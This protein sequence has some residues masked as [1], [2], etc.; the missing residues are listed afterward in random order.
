VIE[1]VNLKM[2]NKASHGT[3]IQPTMQVASS[4]NDSD[5]YSGSAVPKLGRDTYHSGLP[6]RGVPVIAGEYK[7]STLNYTA[8]AFMHFLSY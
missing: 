7:D 8:P 6:F 3:N 5:L 1:A 4:G 2:R